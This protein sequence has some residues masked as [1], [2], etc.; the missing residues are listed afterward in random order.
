MEE[1]KPSF[2]SHSIMCKVDIPKVKINF[3][4]SISTKILQ[5]EEQ[6]KLCP[7]CGLKMKE[8]K[9]KKGR[10]YKSP[11]S[12]YRCNCGFECRKRTMRE[13]L[14]DLGGIE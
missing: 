5:E 7:Y 8:I 3:Q 10:S 12:I 9:I 11:I 1:A 6:D 13:I 4:D 14:R 2:N